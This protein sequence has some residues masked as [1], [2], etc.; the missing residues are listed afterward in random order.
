MTSRPWR[1]ALGGFLPRL[2]PRLCILCELPCGAEPL[3]R[4]CGRFLPG[5]KRRRCRVCARPWQ[6]SP[7]CA[8][9]RGRAPAF[10]VSITAA[11]YCAPLDR[12]LTA[13]KFSG[14]IGLA[15]GLGA[16]LADAWLSAIG[17]LGGLGAD[18]GSGGD[19]EE[20]DRL[21]CLVPIPLS[22]QRQAERGFNQAHLVASAMLKRLAASEPPASSVSPAR[23]LP[24]LRPALLIR[25]RETLAQSLLQWDARQANVDHGFLAAAPVAG[26]RIGVVDDVMTTGATLQ[27]AALALKA[28]GAVRVVNLVVA[29]TA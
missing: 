19:P 26:L 18:G 7:C 27:A 14:Q 20:N 28:A 13:L 3:C 4:P 2:L 12:A 23:T 15:S 5:A 11:D 16:L 29:R 17:G 1:R 25:Q 21:D 22:N 8:S 9:C 10:D 6:I 24:R